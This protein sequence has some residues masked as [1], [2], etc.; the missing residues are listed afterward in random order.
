MMLRP[1][2]PKPIGPD[3][4]HGV[5]YLLSGVLRQWWTFFECFQIR[6]PLLYCPGAMRVSLSGFSCIVLSV[7]L[8]ARHH[9]KIFDAVVNRVAVDMV[10]KFAWFKRASE[11]F[12]HNMPM[13]EHFPPVHHDESITLVHPSVRPRP[14]LTDHGGDMVSD[15]FSGLLISLFGHV[16][17]SF[18][19]GYC[20]DTTFRFNKQLETIPCVLTGKA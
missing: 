3:S 19:L 12:F 5:T 11:M 4:F 14:F 10:D 9:L 13:F 18:S 17:P 8:T 2:R 6:R 16:V 1:A 7:M 20:K 15:M